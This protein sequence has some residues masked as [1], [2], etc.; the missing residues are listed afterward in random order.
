MKQTMQTQCRQFTV[1]LHTCGLLACMHRRNFR[2]NGSV[3][4][5]HF[6]VGAD[7]HFISALRAWS[8]TFQ[9]KVTPLIAWVCTHNYHY[10]AEYAYKC[11]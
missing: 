4:T 11:K 5:P 8:P 1:V 10:S 6:G 2:G 3:R 9:I 7:P